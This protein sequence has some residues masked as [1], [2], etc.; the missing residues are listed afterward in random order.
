[1]A[2]SQQSRRITPATME[3]Q[4]REQTARLRGFVENAAQ[5]A[6]VNIEFKAL[7]GQIGSELQLAAQ[8]MDLLILEKNT[9]LLRQ[10]LRV[11]NIT[12]DVLAAMNCN[13]LLMQ[14]GEIIE[15]PV[16]VLFDGTPAS[17]RALRLAVQLAHGDHDQLIVIYPAADTATQ[18]AWLQ[19]ANA[20]LQPYA[21][22]AGQLQLHS[23]SSSELLH[24]L[25]KC[26]GRVLVVET[27]N[28][29]VNAKS[30]NSLLQQSHVPVIVMR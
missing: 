21:I 5:Q 12:Q 25:L 23:N 6:H 17:E 8:H 13:V 24:A 1:M 28:D 18:Q 15:R 29:V 4:L 7:R 9:P 3:R 22:E 10:S 20:S 11:G 26:N 19:Q 16:A 2:G 27:E 30:I 14:H